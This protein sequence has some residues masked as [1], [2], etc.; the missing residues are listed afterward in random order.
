MLVPLALVGG[1]VVV[2]EVVVISI[3]LFDWCMSTFPAGA[4]VQDLE[5]SRL[6]SL[7]VP[8]PSFLAALH[9]SAPTLA[10]V[11]SALP[12]LLAL[13]QPDAPRAQQMCMELPTTC[14]CMVCLKGRLMDPSG[15]HY[16]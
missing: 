6:L 11:H 4:M 1:A 5:V 10:P 3:F 8:T 2:A 14:T 12:A 15:G 16:C 9:A 7:L 13:L